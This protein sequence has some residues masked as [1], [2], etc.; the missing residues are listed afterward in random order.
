MLKQ[1]IPGRPLASEE[2]AVHMYTGTK[3]NNVHQN[4]RP[5]IPKTMIQNVLCT[6]LRLHAYKIILKHELKRQ[7]SKVSQICR[8]QV[9]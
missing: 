7:S 5:G 8:F 9:K 6:C 4:I 3:K 1:K 2:D